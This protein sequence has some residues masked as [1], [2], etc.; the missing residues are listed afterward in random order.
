MDLWKSVKMAKIQRLFMHNIKKEKEF[1]I[2][3]DER[4]RK[5]PFDCPVCHYALRDT[6]DIISLKKFECCAECQDLYYWPNLEKWKKGWRP[7]LNKTQ[8]K[9]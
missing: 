9:S 2:V 4:Y 1:T 7:I 6:A 5:L 8:N 3:T